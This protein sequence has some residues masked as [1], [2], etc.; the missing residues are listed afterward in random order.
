M[1][2]AQRLFIAD[3]WRDSAD[4]AVLPIIDPATEEQIGSVPVATPTDLDDALEAAEYGAR[5]CRRLSAHERSACLRRM[6]QGIRKQ[7][8]DIARSVTLETGKPLA[9]S[10]A[11]VLATAEHFDW[12]A[13][14]ARRVYGHVLQEREADTRFEVRY[15]PLG[16]VAAITAWNFPALLPGRKLSA[17]LAAGCSVILKPSEEAPSAAFALAEIAAAAG[18]PTGALA[19]VTGD[20]ARISSHLLSSGRVRKLSFT[21]SVGVGKL[22]MQQAAHGLTKLALELGGHGPVLIFPDADPEAT[23]TACARA[24][25]R[26]AGQV[27]IS[28]S[29][30]FVHRSIAARFRDAFV[31]YARDLRIG[32][33]LDPEVEMG[34]L[35]NTRRFEAA[36]ALVADAL[37][38]GGKL[39]AGGGR[40]ASQ[41]RGFFFEPTV[42]ADVAPEARI[43][44]EEPFVPVAPIL[45][46]DD[47]D[48]VLARANAL[49]FGLA[50]Y[51]FTN[52]LATAEHAADALEAGM[53]GINDFALAAAEAPFGG[54][55]QSGIGREGGALGI[56]EFLEAKTLKTVFRGN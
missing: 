4:G 25:F 17:A 6:A 21:G 15:E 11:E 40:P 5:H 2:R 41:Q 24:K 34:P 51:L 54:V 16:V 19:V 37:A 39:L 28:P 42:L 53:V 48:Q 44:H 8:D 3:D 7:S 55:K 9:E 36:Q 56:R 20:P 23:A 46:F 10:R 38:G 12:N 52:D 32:N 26:N 47:F 50:A 1:S 22:L 27:C 45:E 13:E 14:E 29:R 31:R 35:T 49:P 18:L 43:L 30:F 33:G